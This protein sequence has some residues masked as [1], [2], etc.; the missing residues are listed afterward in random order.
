V[1]RL[2]LLARVLERGHRIGD[3]VALGDDA[4]RELL[5][6]CGAAWLEGMLDRARAYDSGGLSAELRKAA[7]SCA[8]TDFL[9]WR[10]VPLARATGEAWARGDLGIGQEH[11]LSQVVEGVLRDLKRVFE[12]SASG[13]PFLLTTLPGELHALPLHMVALLAV[14]RGR[15]SR[16]LGA[17][18]PVPDLVEAARTLRAAAVGISISGVTGR[19]EIT[20]EIARLARLLPRGTELWVGGAG[21]SATGGL[22]PGVRAVGDFFAA[23]EA[24][25]S[26]PD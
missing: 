11:I 1:E 6:G 7:G 10:V 22:V 18:T 12:S 16:V 24:I 19:P 13:R 14:I 4:L 23:D 20:G 26:L 15:A 3:I 8:V 2:R 5:S 25:R 21:S 17:E 9:R